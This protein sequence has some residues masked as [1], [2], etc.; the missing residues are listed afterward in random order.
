MRSGQY[1]HY[2]LL[3]FNQNGLNGESIDMKVVDKLCKLLNI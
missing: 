2:G 3:I 1:P